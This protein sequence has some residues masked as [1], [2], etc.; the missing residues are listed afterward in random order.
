MAVRLDY[1]ALDPDELGR[2]FCSGDEEAFAEIYLRWSRMVF[3]LALRSTGSRT[4]AED[5]VQSV[6]IAAWR[7][8]ASF[9]PGRSS[10]SAWLSGIT[11]HKIVDVHEARGRQD[12]LRHRIASQAGSPSTVDSSVVLSAVLVDQV[13]SLLPPR[14]QQ[15]LR[16]A[17]SDDLTYPEIAARLE[18]PLGTVKSLI[19]RSLLKLRSIL[20]L[21]HAARAELAIAGR[22]SNPTAGR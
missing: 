20:E 11:R 3:H 18:L 10:V 17:F 12:R 21:D 4:D 13:V 16:L 5:V 6:F 22:P 7:S 1:A 2:E 15:L 8:R 19:R 14:N 9:S